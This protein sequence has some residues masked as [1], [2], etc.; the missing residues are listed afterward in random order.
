MKT[1]LKCKYC[2]KE[3]TP[4]RRS[5]CNRFCDKKYGSH[6]YNARIKARSKGAKPISILDE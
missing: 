4:P 2:G 3:L 5:Y 1:P 6:I